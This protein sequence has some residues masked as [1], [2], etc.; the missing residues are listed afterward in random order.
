MI[1]DVK[2]TDDARVAEYAAGVHDLVHMDG[3][4]I[5]PA[6]VTLEV[7]PGPPQPASG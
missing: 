6:A 1:A 2:L 7:M 3:G 5:C 4:N